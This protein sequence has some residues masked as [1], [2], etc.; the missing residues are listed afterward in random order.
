MM[1]YK[2][3]KHFRVFSLVFITQSCFTV[4]KNIRLNSSTHYFGMKIQNKRTS[5]N[6]SSDIDFEDFMSI[7][8]KQTKKTFFF[9]IDITL[10]SGNSS[11]LRNNLLETI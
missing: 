2:F 1:W 5:T 3:K 7:Y 9:I 4:P 10:V 6:H 11:C 8:K